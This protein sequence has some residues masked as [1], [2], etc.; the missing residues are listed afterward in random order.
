M[1]LEHSKTTTALKQTED[2]YVYI[3][4]PSNAFWMNESKIV[5]T[6]IKERII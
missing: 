1:N 4:S 5:L 3:L 6:A 2:S